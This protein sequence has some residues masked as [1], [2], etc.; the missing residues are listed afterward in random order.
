MSERVRAVL[1][2]HNAHKLTELRRIL[3]PHIPELELVS[4]DGPEPAETG[5][6]F[7]ENALIKARA[8]AAHTGLP[9]LADDSGISVDVLGGSP[10]IFSARWS[11]PARSDAQNVDLLLWQLQDVPDE[12]RGANFTAAAALVIPG[13]A[14]AVV[15][16]AWPGRIARDRSGEGGFGYDPIFVPEGESR[17]AAELLPAEKDALSHRRRAFEA[18]APRLRELL[19]LQ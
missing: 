2:S 14:E 12:H 1:A 7:A 17:S 19:G 18:L 9:A 15:E 5:V 8:A 13:G 3:E 6:T 4:Y 11:G 16:G 10:G